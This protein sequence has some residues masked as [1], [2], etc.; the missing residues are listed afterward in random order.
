MKLLQ[1]IRDTAREMAMGSKINDIFLDNES[2][3]GWTTVSGAAAAKR[4]IPET[5]EDFVLEG[6]RKNAVVRACMNEILTSLSEAPIYAYKP[7]PDEPEGYV[8]L[9]GHHAETVFSRPNK[10]DDYVRFIE[11]TGQHFLLG[12]NS[13]WRKKRSGS[14]RVIG[15]MPIT[16][17]R[18]TSAIIDPDGVPLGFRIRKDRSSV[19]TEVVPATEIVHVAD[20]DPLNDIFGAP[21]LLACNMDVASDNQASGY[22]SEVLSNH[23]VPAL[24]IGTPQH[25]EDWQLD[26]AEARMTQKF[27]PGLGRGKIG[28]IPSTQSVHEIGFDLKELE[29]PSLRRVSGERICAVL[30]PVDPMI[31]AIGSASR[32]GTLSGAEHETALVKLWVQCIIP[33]IRRYESV[34]NAHVAPEWGDIRLFFA[35]EEIAALQPDRKADI[36]RGKLMAEA[37]VFTD[38]EIRTEAGWPAQPETDGILIGPMNMTRMPWSTRAE[39]PEGEDEAELGAQEVDDDQRPVGTEAGRRVDLERKLLARAVLGMPGPR[40]RKLFMQ[41]VWQRY[42]QIGAA[43]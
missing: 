22:V 6:F 15:F 5:F 3:V 28:F 25:V 31:V 8:R 2:G 33:L 40:S 13:F 7:D 16:P 21:R 39:E 42:R 24:L 36:E 4:Q 35:I 10:R 30:G 11:K 43:S 18:V 26:R 19:E 34:L 38:E 32:G 41:K 27:G 1:A 14:T 37:A 17:D 23:G 9:P 12:G 29:F 20:M